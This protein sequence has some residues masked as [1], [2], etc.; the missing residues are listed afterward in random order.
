MSNIVGTFCGQAATVEYPTTSNRSVNCWE[1][2][3]GSNADKKVTT[4]GIRTQKSNRGG[5]GQS[6]LSKQ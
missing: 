6:A 2:H 4:A 5:G 1:A 3:N